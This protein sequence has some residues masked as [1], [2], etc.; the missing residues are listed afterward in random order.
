MDMNC[1][2]CGFDLKDEDGYA[3]PALEVNLLGATPARKRVEEIFGEHKFRFCHVCYLKRLG[4]K[5]KKQKEKITLKQD[6]SKKP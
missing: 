1:S 5:T 6:T 4:A 2:A 3:T